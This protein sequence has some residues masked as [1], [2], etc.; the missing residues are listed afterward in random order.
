MEEVSDRQSGIVNRSYDDYF[1]VCA[2][3]DTLAYETH[4]LFGLNALSVLMQVYVDGLLESV[5]F[6]F[7]Q[8]LHE[9][10]QKKKALTSSLQT[11]V[12]E[13]KRSIVSEDACCKQKLSRIKMLIKQYEA[14]QRASWEPEYR[15]K[16]SA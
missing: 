14:S 7:D 6:T 15:I 1:A 13:R 5:D 2:Q 9:I 4:V 8:L 10:E 11:S 3:T 12:R 16:A